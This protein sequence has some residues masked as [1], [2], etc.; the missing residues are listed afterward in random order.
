MPYTRITGSHN[1]REAIEYALEGEGHNGNE[2]RNL[3]VTS[4]GLFPGDA[5]SYADQMD[6]YWKKATSKNKNQ[7]RR[8]I[9]SYSK[10]ELDPADPKSAIIA[11]EIAREHAQRY[12]PD[13]QVLICVQA[14][15]VGGCLHTHAI[16][17]NVSMTDFKGCTDEQTKFHYVAK[18]VDEVAKEY[19]VLSMDYSDKFDE[20]TMKAKIPS[21]IV[22]QN[23]RRQRDENREAEARGE[24]A[25]NYI[26]KDDLKDRVRQAM[27]EAKDRDDFLK[28]LT[29][30][31]VEGTYRT[32]KKQGDFILYELVDVT[33]FPDKVPS[34]LKSKSYKMGSDFGLEA[35]DAE[36]AKHKSYTYQSQPAYTPQPAVQKTPEELEADRK[37][38]EE[39]EKFV[40]WCHDNGYSLVDDNE[41]YDLDKAEVAREAYN[42]YLKNPKPQK[43]QEGTQTDAVDKNVVEDTKTPKIDKYDVVSDIPTVIDKKQAEEPTRTNKKQVQEPTKTDNQKPVVKKQSKR[44]EMVA[45]LM[46]DVEMMKQR[47]E[48]DQDDEQFS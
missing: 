38:S 34:N 39:A 32:S 24:V 16:I 37:R 14:D 20:K 48:E 25:P 11:G 7:V 9:T 2:V 33:G 28:R 47:Q 8:L 42:Q 18:T 36:L 29:A 30:H 1:G 12:Y 45:K 6:V 3:Y 10:N 40:N 27:T 21:D 15:G 22:K 4:V 35:L 26:W 17:S 46:R 44:D 13:R 19:M 5:S 41:V 43:A 23:E 31:G